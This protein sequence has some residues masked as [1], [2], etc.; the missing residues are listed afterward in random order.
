MPRGRVSLWCRRRPVHEAC[1]G[2][3]ARAHGVDQIY[4]DRLE[5]RAEPPTL[6][7]LETAAHGASRRPPA[8]ERRLL[9]EING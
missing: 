1:V 4:A 8:T 5:K 6:A 3:Y 2:Q 7:E 9:S